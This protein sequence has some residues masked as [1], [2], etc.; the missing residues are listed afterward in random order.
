MKLYLK[1]GSITKAKDRCEKAI[2]REV[3]KYLLN[4]QKNTDV[5]VSRILVILKVKRDKTG[6]ITVRKVKTYLD[7]YQ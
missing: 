6:R 7:V 3:K 5:D 4:F 2:S 1:H